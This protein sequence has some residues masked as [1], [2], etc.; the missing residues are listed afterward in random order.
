MKTFF[1]DMHCHT[2]LKP[3]GQSFES[4]AGENS[5]NSDDKNSIWHRNAPSGLT[6]VV[7]DLLG[8]AKFTQA[9]FYSLVKGNCKLICASMYPI[10]KGFFN[11]KL[12]SGGVSRVVD[13]FI[14]GVGGKRV[15]DVQQANDYF[16]GLKKE[17]GFYKQLNGTQ[18][19][20][21]GEAYVYKLIA[22]YEEIE[23]YLTDNPQ[24]EN[25]L[26]VILTIEGMH[27][28]NSNL[29]VPASKAD[30]LKNLAEMKKWDYT[31][32]FV[33]VCHHFNNYLCGHAKSLFDIVGSEIDQSDAIDTG[34]T[35]LGWKVV[36][37]MLD[38]TGGQKRIYPDVKHM[39]IKGRLEYYAFL[40][41]EYANKIPIIVSHGAANGMRSHEETVI[42][43]K[44][45]NTFFDEDINFFDNEIILLAKSGGI[46]GLQM[47]EHRIASKEAI[48]DI[49]GEIL[50]KD[51]RTMRSKLVWNQIQ[52]IAELLDEAHLP[53]WDCLAIGSDSD[54]II[55]P[56]N[57]FLTEET[58]P[59]LFD[60]VWEY[61]DA[62]M[63]S[64]RAKSLNPEN[65]LVTADIMNKVFHL[66]AKAF[67]KKWFV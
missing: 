5:A 21:D 22:K 55:N 26:F 38:N 7:Q 44:L 25:V 35:D 45:G 14:T 34:F 13:N 67:L 56:I 3:F 10:E 39:S 66:N 17:Y 2:A 15:K 16:A 29:S 63:K 32:F 30:F 51:V 41:K 59:D 28:L 4:N 48:A 40:E 20:I 8:I 11:N 6:A 52:Y 18:V 65:R 49:A 37:A 1:V 12:G 54:G 64:D 23:K 31:P 53:A 43:A 47:D 57:G 42:D 62:Y 50:L 33:S 58:L 27:V 24:T 60:Y 19:T 9:D 61:A 36:R 46:M